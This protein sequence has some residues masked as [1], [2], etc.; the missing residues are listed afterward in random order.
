MVKFTVGVTTQAM[1]R[2]WN[3]SRPFQFHTGMLQDEFLRAMR[4]S[5]RTS[6]TAA[7]ETLER[8]GDA[9]LSGA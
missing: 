5:I 6:L 1:A 9:G 2:R 3:V 4:A 8:S 7:S